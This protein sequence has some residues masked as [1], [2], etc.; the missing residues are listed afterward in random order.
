M[1]EI[2][3]KTILAPSPDG[4]RMDGPPNTAQWRVRDEV[5]EFAIA[6]EA[7]LRKH[8]SKTHWK[9][10]PVEALRRLMMLEIEEYNVAREFF[11]FDE[12]M[13][14]L[15]DIANFAM[16]LRDRYRIERD[17]APPHLHDI[18][19]KAAFTHKGETLILDTD[20]AGGKGHG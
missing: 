2:T 14:E 19:G 7:K 9:Q 13:A 16:M 5:G 10:L 11:G 8:D 4:F 18:G 12:T 17:K 1:T 3:S 15:V 20:Q 6:M